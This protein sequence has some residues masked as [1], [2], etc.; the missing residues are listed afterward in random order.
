M[1]AEKPPL[2]MTDIMAAAV[3]PALI[4][5]LVGS[6]VF[7]LVEVL[8][9]GN[10]PDNLLWGLFFFVIAA[11]LIARIST[12]SPA[13]ARVYA[14]ALAVPVW[15]T[16]QFFI[17][18]PGEV[19]AV[20]KGAIN[21]GLM[22]V[23]WWSAHRLTWDCTFIDEKDETE[24][25]G[26]LQAAGLEKAGRKA[27]EEAP[28]P[29]EKP[30]RHRKET[31]WERYCRYCEEQRQRR[32]PGVWIV[33]FSLAALPLFGLGQSLIPVEDEGRRQ[34]VFWLMVIYVASGLGLLLT[35]CYLG[36]RRYLRQR[37]VKM[38]ASM[39]VAWLATGGVI[40]AVLLALG[41]LLPRPNAEYPVTEMV[42]LGSP[43]RGASRWA[44]KNGSPGKG[45]GRLAAKS[46]KLQPN[47][48]NNAGNPGKQGGQGNKTQD[49]N[50]AKGNAG[51]KD[52]SDSGDKQGSGQGKSQGNQSGGKS[53]QDEKQQDGGKQSEQGNKDNS[54]GS[55][56]GSQS[57]SGEQRKQDGEK[58]S[59]NSSDQ[60]SSPPSNSSSLW[61]LV[62]GLGPV[63]K[64]IV[65]GVIVVV[66]VFFVLRGALQFLANFT[67]WARDL[68][69]ALR[70]WWQG[71]FAR[72]GG[73]K[74][75]AV[76]AGEAVAQR[77]PPRPF[78]S[79]LNPFLSGNAERQSLE[80][81]IRYSFEAME[82]WAWEH[83]LGRQADETPLEF[84]ERIGSELPAFEAEARQLANLYA[85]VL[86][87]RDKLPIS[88]REA[89][90]QFWE[91]LEA[92]VEQPMSA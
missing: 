35:T 81:L 55:Q 82:A 80:K 83:D 25:E 26:L 3:S 66:V 40:I 58:S 57:R 16:L 13:R 67:N 78:A 9:V 51:S 8:Y 38:P 22:A 92:V 12:A 24:G 14:A 42:G 86:Y 60:S 34:Y 72:K 18:Y 15:L 37:Q 69:A 7:F 74:T 53:K 29:E 75:G 2:S 30:E 36:L 63:A 87:A 20:I 46:P 28:V 1:T 65:F 50:A 10:Y 19:P 73:E 17:E 88:A 90:R 89:L 43:E 76:G 71:L 4:V 85:R 33:Y 84:A 56:E 64:W 70:A 49:P 6:L 79:F 68:L 54:G 62:T 45:E 77:S 59:S 31:W 27:V 21:L 52:S 39:T 61:Q 5:T 41:A 91:R 11:V 32:T 23:V 44:V 47:E 48:E